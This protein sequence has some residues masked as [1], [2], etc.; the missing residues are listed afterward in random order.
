MAEEGVGVTRRE[1][2]KR[3]RAL[4]CCGLVAVRGKAFGFVWEKAFVMPDGE[5]PAG[6]CEWLLETTG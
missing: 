5:G 1:L 3:R 6:V 4:L 2:A